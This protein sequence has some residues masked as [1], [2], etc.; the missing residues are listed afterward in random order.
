[1]KKDA[2]TGD[3]MGV[4]ATLGTNVWGVIHTSDTETVESSESAGTVESRESA[5]SESGEIR[6]YML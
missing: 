6:F 4:T 3:V 1:M 5:E 2:D